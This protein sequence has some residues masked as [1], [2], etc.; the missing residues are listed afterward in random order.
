MLAADARGDARP[1][2]DEIIAFDDDPAEIIGAGGR[3][4]AEFL[5]DPAAR[6]TGAWARREGV[7][8]LRMELER[9]CREAG[10]DVDDVLRG[11]RSSE[12]SR[13]RRTLILYGLRVLQLPQAVI[14]TALAVSRTSVW[15]LVDAPGGQMDSQARLQV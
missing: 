15:R 13:V 14:A 8:L 11:R 2:W 4:P 7:P 10:I 12:V 1:P 5:R 3:N 9:V 6:P